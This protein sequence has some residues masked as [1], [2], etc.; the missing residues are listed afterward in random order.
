MFG[1]DAIWYTSEGGAGGALP[2]GRRRSDWSERSRG[3]RK[4][5]HGSTHLELGKLALKAGGGR[6]PPGVRGR[7]YAL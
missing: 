5:V 7:D 4:W 1:E 6:R 2:V 3:R